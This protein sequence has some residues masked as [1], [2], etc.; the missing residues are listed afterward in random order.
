[1]FRPKINGK[2]V[3]RPSHP[4]PNPGH[5][6]EVRAAALERDGHSCRCCPNDAA[7]G[8]SLE[9]HHRHYNTWG[10]ETVDDV[11][12]LCVLC[13]D[14]ITSRIRETTE[15]KIVS[16][17]VMPRADTPTVTPALVSV[18]GEVAP[19][20]R[21]VRPTVMLTRVSIQPSLTAGLPPRDKPSR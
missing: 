5:W 21:P 10:R 8:V 14:A 19:K 18:R 2:N 3:T 1:M 11:V 17:K 13:H 20:E 7:S 15:Y 6:D 12:T 9:I 4:H 16:A